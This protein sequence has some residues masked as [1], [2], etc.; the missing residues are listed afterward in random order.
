MR[1]KET[2]IGKIPFEWEVVTI[3]NALEEIIDYRG[4]TPAKSETGIVTL[5]AKSV[6]NGYIDYSKAYYISELIYQ[7]FMVRGFPQKGDILLTTEAPLGL[8]AKLNREKVAIAQRLL[9][10]RGKKEYLSNDYL[11][12]YF[13]SDEGQHQLKSRQS[14]TTVTGIKQKEFRKCLIS[15]PPFEEQKAI[16]HILSTL[17]EKI[18]VNN[19]INKTLENIAQTIFKQWFVDFEFPNGAKE[20]YKSSGGEMVESELGMIPKGWEVT[21]LDEICNFISGYSYKGNELVASNNAMITIKNFD[22]NGGFKLDGYKEISIS[23]RVKDKHFVSIFDILVAHTDLTQNAEII[24]NP[25]LVTNTMSYKKII[26]SMDTVKVD[27]I[28]ENY[29]FYIYGLLLDSNFKGYAL[30]NMNGTTV[31]HLSKKALPDYKFVKASN[32]LIERYNYLV[33][34]LYEKIINI[35]SENIALNK[36]RDSLLPKLMSGEIRVPIEEN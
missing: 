33:K 23:D 8:V 24:G 1:F 34:P 13:M 6:K 36:L 17:D 20:P 25:I 19:Q 35:Y 31:L 16:A 10:L 4:K 28:I 14:G 32:D 29:R 12:Y 5:S 15:I 21:K 3:E 30:G 9:T 22:R 11:M 18:E 27:P 7:K 26:F 2:E